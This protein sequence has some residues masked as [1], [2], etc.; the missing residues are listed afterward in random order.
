MFVCR[1]T[2]NHEKG[3]CAAHPFRGPFLECVSLT[4]EWAA[5]CGN[6]K[7]RDGAKKCSHNNGDGPDRYRTTPAGGDAAAEL[8]PPPAAPAT[9]NVVTDVPYEVE[10]P[11]EEDGRVPVVL[12]LGQ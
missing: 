3:E 7:F 8:N 9:G 12:Q 2:T 4:Y 5:C 6:C 10:E 11:E 1:T